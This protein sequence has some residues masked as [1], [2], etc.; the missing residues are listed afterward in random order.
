MSKNSGIGQLFA[1]PRTTLRLLY[2]HSSISLL[3]YD[4]FRPYPDGIA[5]DDFGGAH[6]HPR[7][8]SGANI[9]WQPV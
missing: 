2:R 4:E 6:H 3:P 5:V 9:S 1:S 7:S 8:L